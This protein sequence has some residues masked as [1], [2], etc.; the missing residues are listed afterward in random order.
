M[1]GRSVRFGRFEGGDCVGAYSNPCVEIFGGHLKVE[2][3]GRGGGAEGVVPKV[4]GNLVP[5]PVGGAGLVGRG[6]E[7]GCD[8]EVD[9]RV[10]GP[11]DLGGMIVSDSVADCEDGVQCVPGD[12][13]GVGCKMGEA[14]VVHALD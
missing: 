2:G 11:G 12:V 10:V 9:D 3:G 4:F 8:C 5:A 1:F 13:C 7:G 14:M 6:V